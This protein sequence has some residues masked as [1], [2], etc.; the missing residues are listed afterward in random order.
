MIKVGSL[1]GSL[2]REHYYFISA[3]NLKTTINYIYFN[4]FKVLQ[5]SSIGY[6]YEFSYSFNTINEQYCYLKYNFYTHFKLFIFA[7]MKQCCTT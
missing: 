4:S 2:E 1:G 7:E 3:F 5:N 6:E